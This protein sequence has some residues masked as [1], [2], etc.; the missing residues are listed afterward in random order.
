MPIIDLEKEKTERKDAEFM[1]ASLSRD[2]SSLHEK[3]AEIEAEIDQ[4]RAI[5]ASLERGEHISC[6]R[7]SF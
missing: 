3:V 4:Y 5:V 7:L 6:A 1:V 2:L